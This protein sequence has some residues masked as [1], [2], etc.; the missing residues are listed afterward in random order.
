MTPVQYYNAV[1][2]LYVQNTGHGLLVNP[3][4]LEA[5]HSDFGYVS[6]GG[7][8]YHVRQLH[9]HMPSEHTINGE[10]AAAELHIVHQ[11]HGATGTSNLLV[12]GILYNEGPEDPTLRK[13]G[14]PGSAPTVT[15]DNRPVVGTMEL[16]T[17]EG[18]FYRYEGSL[19]TPPCSETVKWFVM[20]T[21]RTVSAAQM[22]T[23]RQIF[24]FNTHRDTQPLYGRPVV[25]N[26]HLV[27]EVGEAH[28]SA[29][30]EHG[31]HGAHH[32]LPHDEGEQ[33]VAHG[34]FRN[35]A[36]A[37]GGHE[38]GHEEG[39]AGGHGDS[40]EQS[41]VMG[42]EGDFNYQ[43]TRCWTLLDSTCGSGTQQ[44]PIEIKTADITTVGEDVFMNGVE[45]TPLP[46]GI[47]VLN[48]GH[49]IVASTS[50]DNV[51][52]H[53]ASTGH[54]IVSGKQYNLKFFK[55]HMPAEH[56]ID[57]VLYHGEIQLVHQLNGAHGDN[58][59]LIASIMVDIGAENVFLKQLGIPD[60]IPAAHEHVL[61]NTTLEVARGVGLALEG[62]F[63]RYDG[64]LT[65]PP[66]TESVKWFVF[67]TVMT[68]SMPQYDAFTAMFPAPANNRPLQP[69]NGRQVAL[70]DADF[71][72][73][74][75]E[76]Y[77]L[78]PFPQNYIEPSAILIPCAMTLI[79][80][81][82]LMA[83]TFVSED[84]RRKRH[85]AGGLLATN[86]QSARDAELFGQVPPSTV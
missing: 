17:L 25:M 80:C 65:T 19:T 49:T 27:G 69:L 57:S 45:Y 22:E 41:H 14:V 7:L 84:S 43:D 42:Y 83:I 75:F 3:G 20:E 11:L 15:F 31:S 73:P 54:V 51:H 34:E 59:L 21:Q 81:G 70:S 74:N 50:V 1:D 16:P 71:P 39:H 56:A 63:F 53:T 86:V 47:S 4:H 32:A 61:T 52:G 29:V 46:P 26:H 66:C 82:A 6:I 76:G 28:C 24:P 48:N 60:A 44:S 77:G 12:I 62:G 10:L 23:F 18:N 68:M 40:F 2:G 38:G 35:L 36:D 13:M 30:A 33:H 78:H 8:L 9:W 37:H 64:S 67:E 5:F 72:G 79:L 58:D 85:A 55:V